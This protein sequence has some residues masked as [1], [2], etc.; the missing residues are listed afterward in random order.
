[1]AHIVNYGED[2][3]RCTFCGK[4]EHQVHRLVAGPG[5]N[6]CDE[7]ITLCME[8]IQEGDQKDAASAELALPSPAQILAFLDSYV[9]GQ[10][11]A[12]Q[13][14]SV[15]V[16]NHYKL[17]HL[18]ALKSGTDAHPSGSTT[19][20]GFGFGKDRDTDP[21]ADVELSKSNVLL[22]GP[23]GT[24]K[25]YLARTLARM[26]KVPFVIV[27]ATTLTEAGYVGDDV[28]TILQ[29]LLQAADGDVARAEKGIIYVDE[30]DK[31]AR[32][33]G[34]NT[35]ITRDVS[36]EGVQQALLKIL[37]GTIASVPKEGS[38]KHQDQEMVQI[39]TRNILFICAGA[40][41]G[42]NDII[43]ARLGKHVTGFGSNLETEATTRQEI[44]YL[45]QVIPQDL[46]DFGF[47]P[48]FVG[49][50]PVVTSLQPLTVEDLER[51]ITE[52]ANA[53]VKQYQKLFA[54]DGVT[55]HF[56]D[57]AVKRLAAI[58]ME[59]GTGARGLRSIFEAV[60]QKT[61][62]DLPDRDE[63]T[64]VIV[65]SDTVDGVAPPQLMARNTRL[66]A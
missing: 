11:A 40:F 62:F 4:S 3:P 52:P 16:Y 9:I 42:L 48:E 39:D 21:L 43:A 63:V 19:S 12:K 13:A 30:I 31:I 57:D 33:S 41:V 65:N 15:A 49:R 50:L 44:D 58:A 7:C 47:L 24:G 22:L 26:M 14:L 5:A 32:K 1:M 34:E 38:R 51:I 59:K 8:I 66:T 60:L 18:G 54:L 25:T 6:I 55:L 61:M 10:H 53:L 27:D 36:G 2:V 28:E 46:I 45:D 17:V 35:S 20:G 37:E 29:R 23:T 64:D 56:T